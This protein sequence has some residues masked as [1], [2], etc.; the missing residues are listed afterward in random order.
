MQGANSTER[1]IRL[2]YSLENLMDAKRF[3][4]FA[5]VSV[6]IAVLTSHAMAQNDVTGTCNELVDHIINTGVVDDE[7]HPHPGYSGWTNATFGYTFTVDSAH[8]VKCPAVC[9][10][11]AC[12]S[13]TAH[14]KLTLKSVETRL[15][16][17]KPVGCD[18][19]ACNAQRDEWKGRVE[20]HE[21]AHEKDANARVANFNSQ[22]KDFPVTA[23]IDRRTATVEAAMPKLEAAADGKGKEAEEAQANAWERDQAKV[24]KRIGLRVQDPDCTKCVVCAAGEQPACKECPPG[25]VLYKGQCFSKCGPYVYPAWENCGYLADQIT[26]VQC[27]KINTPTEMF[28]CA[29]RPSN[30]CP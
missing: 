18:P 24:H 14:I 7:G 30:V 25:Q 16:S 28:V 5:I 4:I 17:W 15:I 29:P 11:K 12:F 10:R 23:C 21:K 1:E 13:A 6:F 3:G 8:K 9:G 19:C 20:T 2:S 22:P 27:C 26:P